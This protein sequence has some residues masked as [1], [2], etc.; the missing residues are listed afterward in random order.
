[1]QTTTT[2]LKHE[3]NEST[4]GKTPNQETLKAC[5]ELR[6]G[7]GISFTSLDELFKYL[8]S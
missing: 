5:Q 3:Q 4:V 8:K 2:V 6:N 1:M 7:D